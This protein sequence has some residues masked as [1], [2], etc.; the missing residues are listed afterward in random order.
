MNVAEDYYVY[1]YIDPRNYQEFYYGKGKGINVGEFELHR[2]WEDCRAHGFLSAGFGLR[3]KAQAL[4]LQKDDL[5]VAYLSGQGYV[6]IGR[7]TAEAVPAR[8]FRIG[9]TPLAKMKLTA[10]K[11]CHDSDDLEKCEYVV[12]VRWLVG[13]KR[14][15]ALWKRGLFRARQT[16]VSLENQPKTL[17]YLEAEWG[18]KFEVLLEKDGG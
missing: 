7:V 6:G 15:E 13:K 8:D 3:Y 16:R 9:R 11:I 14:E 12:R 2:A 4:Q 5:A 10:P 17:R 18:K 1:C